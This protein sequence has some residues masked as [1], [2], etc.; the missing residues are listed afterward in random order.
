MNETG[1]KEA[2]RAFF[3]DN[4]EKFV[5]GLSHQGQ[6][7]RI[8]RITTASFVFPR[9]AQCFIRINCA[10]ATQKTTIANA[11]IPEQVYGKCEYEMVV[12]LILY[13]S[14]EVNENLPYEKLTQ[15]FTTIS[16]RIME[17]L[18]DTHI[19]K[20]KEYGCFELGEEITMSTED[21][22]TVDTGEPVLVKV[23]TFTLI[24]CGY[25]VK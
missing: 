21:T 8:D 20:D 17:I 10:S 16:D 4:T 24:D 1:A 25:C 12:E 13:A 22:Y 18:N 23:Y 15:T 3:M 11:P 6:P 14:P 9:I 2:L 5:D 7:M 19:I